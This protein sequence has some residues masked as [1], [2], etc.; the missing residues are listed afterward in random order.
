[1][2]TPQKRDRSN[3]DDGEDIQDMLAQL[4]ECSKK[5]KLNTTPSKKLRK[6]NVTIQ[7]YGNNIHAIKL[8][9]QDDGTHAYIANLMKEL[10]KYEGKDGDV[11]EGH[12]IRLHDCKILGGLN[13]RINH[14]T[15]LSV[16]VEGNDKRWTWKC[17]VVASNHLPKKL[18]GTMFH[19]LVFDGIKRLIADTSDIPVERINRKYE[20]VSKPATN[21]INAMDKHYTD[22]S[23]GEVVERYLL[24]GIP[25]NEF[26]NRFP[27]DTA[28]YFS[29]KQN[30]QFSPIA[31]SYGYGNPIGHNVNGQT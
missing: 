19:R 15:N 27:D 7:E 8:S 2:E 26:F 11:P 17:I 28:N 9:H 20:L 1:M 14:E 3:D 12:F 16:T 6:V 24:N 13:L 29:A 4:A 30:G 23:V 18:Q 21:I 25:N 10:G 22:G 5:V 31:I